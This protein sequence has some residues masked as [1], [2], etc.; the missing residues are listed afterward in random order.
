MQFNIFILSQT[1]FKSGESN[2][3]KSIISKDLAK[4]SFNN[5]FNNTFNNLFNNLT[6][7]IAILLS[8]N[9]WYFIHIINTCQGKFIYNTTSY[10]SLNTTSC[11]YLSY[12]SKLL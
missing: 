8:I 10:S 2:N 6:A 9:D 5:A 4:D 1:I 11:T 7:N 12:S 3:N